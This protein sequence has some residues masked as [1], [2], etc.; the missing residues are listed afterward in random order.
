METKELTQISLDVCSNSD[1]SANVNFGDTNT[2][3][4][5]WKAEGGIESLQETE[6]TALLGL[7]SNKWKSTDTSSWG[8]G[9]SYKAK[10]VSSGSGWVLVSPEGSKEYLGFCPS[11]ANSSASQ[12][13]FLEVDKLSV[14]N[15]TLKLCSKNCWTD[16]VSAGLQSLQT[17]NAGNWKEVKFFSISQ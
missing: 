5:C 11:S 16:S 12:Q 4:A 3:T 2:Q 9:Q 13:S 7:F 15:V 10:C 6:K 1:S 17:P 8:T 14:K